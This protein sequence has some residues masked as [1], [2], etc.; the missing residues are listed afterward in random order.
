MGDFAGSLRARVERA[1]EAVRIAAASGDEYRAQLHGAD[2][3]NLHRLAA[4]HGVELAVSPGD[5]AGK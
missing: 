2:L 4:E 5:A 1:Q 3:A